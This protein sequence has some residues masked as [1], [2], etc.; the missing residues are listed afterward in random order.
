M[1]T[2]ENALDAASELFDALPEHDNPQYT[3]GQAELIMDLYDLEPQAAYLEV[4]TET[5]TGHRATRDAL[6][7]IDGIRASLS[8]S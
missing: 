3:R 7:R 5:I 1:P 8:R 6:E 2:L 4:V